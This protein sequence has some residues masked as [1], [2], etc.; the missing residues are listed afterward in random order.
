MRDD[1]PHADLTAADSLE[2]LSQFQGDEYIKADDARRIIAGFVDA[3]EAALPEE[4]DAIESDGLWVNRYTA[5]VSMLA[6]EARGLPNVQQHHPITTVSKLTATIATDLGLET[7]E[8][9]SVGT[10]RSSREQ[11]EGTMENLKE[12]FDY[13]EPDEE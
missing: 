13:S 2:E 10:A 4:H 1:D 8:S 7:G 5:N 6:A 3:L 11:Y 12:Y 9:S